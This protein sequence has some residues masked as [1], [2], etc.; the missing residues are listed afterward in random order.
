MLKLYIH[1]PWGFM[2]LMK[3]LRDISGGLVSTEATTAQWSQGA[4]LLC[5]DLPTAALELLA[6]QIAGHGPA[7]A[8]HAPCPGSWPTLSAQEGGAWGN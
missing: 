3:T 8:G 5:K 6:A 1:E 2:P 7:G 4:H